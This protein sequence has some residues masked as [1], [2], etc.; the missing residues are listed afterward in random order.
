MSSVIA[1]TL[2]SLRDADGL[3]RIEAVIEAA[4][5]PASP[6]HEHFEWDDGEA[7]HLYRLDQARE[8]IRAQRIPV[9]IGPTTIRAV[10]YI[11][12][13]NQTGA[14]QVL[15]DVP[16]SSDLARSV[17]LSEL[18]RVGGALGRARNIAAVL[19]LEAELDDL[20]AA[21]SMVRERAAV[22]PPVKTKA[23]AR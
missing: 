5:D 7:A 9:K 13:V 20:L 14:Y 10:T 11:P 22:A 21:L 15:R 18:S 17:M 19:G 8:I 6:L 3:L 2:E 12:A 23:K 16:P 4:E 1:D